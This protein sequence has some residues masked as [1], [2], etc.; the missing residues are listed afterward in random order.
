MVLDED[1]LS[2]SFIER[3]EEYEDCEL[4]KV[5]VGERLLLSCK[6]SLLLFCEEASWLFNKDTCSVSIMSVMNKG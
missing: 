1:G 6:I 4:F 5:E 3:T 2:K